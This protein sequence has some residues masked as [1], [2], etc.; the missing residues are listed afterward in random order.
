MRLNKKYYYRFETCEA[1]KMREGNIIIRSGEI[2]RADRELTNIM[3][4]THH[5]GMI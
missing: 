2:S 1:S 5:Q 4:P 3:T